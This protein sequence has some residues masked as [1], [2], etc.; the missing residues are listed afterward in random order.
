MP[1]TCV[2]FGCNSC[3]DSNPEK[4]PAF[5]FPLTKHTHLLPYWTRFV[6]LSRGGGWEPTRSSVICAKHFRPNF[7]KHC[8]IR[9]KL[10]WK[11]D[12]VPDIPSK[13]VQENYP[14]TIFRSDPIRPRKAPQIRPFQPCELSKFKDED[15]IECI[16]DLEQKHCHEN[17]TFEK[18][19]GYCVYYNLK[20]VNN[21]FPQVFEC[22]KIDKDL[23]V[24]LFFNGKPVP[25]PIWFVKGTNA[26]LTSFGALQ[27]FPAYLKEEDAN[28][29]YKEILDE[30]NKRKYFKP[31]GRPPFSPKVLRYALILRHTSLQA[32]KL[33]LEQFPLPSLSL[34][35]KLQTGG[36]DAIKAIKLL[37]EKG[38]LS[39]DVI[40]M[41]DEMYLQKS[42][43]YH[44]G[45][46]VG[47]DEEDRKYKG[48]LV[49]MISGLKKSTPYV[50]KTCPEVEINGKWVFEQ[51]DDAISNLAKSGFNVRAV[52]A[53][54]HSSNVSAYNHLLVKYENV[55]VNLSIKH[56]DNESSIFLF[57]DN[58]HLVKNLRNNL[59]NAKKFVFPSFSFNVLD[60]KSPQTF[61]S[62]TASW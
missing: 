7:L 50:I 33:L 55:H 27:N 56:P 15:K 4:V 21:C 12:P 23:H 17:W 1:D 13:E 26:K 18:H 59:I 29:E 51:I 35:N 6:N 28:N 44:G 60:T 9:T 5:Y 54:N 57:F 52:V 32:Y 34:L 16:D 30:L 10:H 47:A 37:R 48:V 25:L 11:L 3:Y 41:L 53:D 61:L 36:V 58:V 8:K 22:I 39:Q 20:M 45:D 49:F 31:Q 42:T 38:E 62:S 40:L 2:V 24:Q 46:Y 19:D 14:S 43:Q